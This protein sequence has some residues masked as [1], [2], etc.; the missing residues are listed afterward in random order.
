MY[1][2]DMTTAPYNHPPLVGWWL[3]LNNWLVDL[4]AAMPFLIRLPAILADIVTALLVFELVRMRRPMREAGIAG[5]VVAASPV[6]VIIS[7]YH[8][9]TDPVF[10]MF[11]VL[12]LYLLLPG[13]T[14]PFAALA[15]VCIAVAMSIKLVPVVTLPLLVLVALRLGRRRLFAFLGGTAAVFAVLWGPVV[16]LR[17]GPFNANV[18]QYAGYGGR[19]TWGLPQFAHALGASP[20]FLDV[21]LRPGRWVVL[22]LAA[23]LAVLLAWRRP[24]ATTAAFGLSYC[25]FLLL[26]TATATQYLAWAAA[27]ACLLNVWVAIAYN[28]SAGLLLIGVYDR[29]SGA[30][31]WSWDRARAS[32]FDRDEIWAAAGVWVVLLIVC[33][34]SMYPRRSPESGADA[35]SL[36]R[37]HPRAESSL[38]GAR[39]RR[40]RRQY[41]ARPSAMSGPHA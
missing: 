40:R 34:T 19:P 10:L 35:E 1:G 39:Q 12:S 26:S 21:L 27:A 37:R 6:L 3:H 38:D 24:E 36:Q 8:G 16:A 11:S 23:G 5:L 41:R 22:L 29:W 32:P 2:Q 28:L 14:A 18:L 30:Y 4:G 20:E 17:W 31:P 7:G 9:N 33:A 13:R 15:G 25:L